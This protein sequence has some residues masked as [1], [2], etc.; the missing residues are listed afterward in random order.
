MAVGILL[1]LWCPT[2]KSWQNQPDLP[3][4]NSAV[5]RTAE[6]LEKLDRRHSAPPPW[7]SGRWVTILKTRNV[8]GLDAL[9]IQSL[10]V[11]L[12]PPNDPQSWRECIPPAAPQGKPESSSGYMKWCSTQTGK[13]QAFTK[14]SILRLP[15][16][17]WV[18]F[19]QCPVCGH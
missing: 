7:T 5:R 13:T 14:N 12:P 17:Q 18:S 16:I 8:N 10:P 4:R 2:P 19:R 9:F 1:S 11:I 6:H 15:R 3:T